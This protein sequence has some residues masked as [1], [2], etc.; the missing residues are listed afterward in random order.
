M[1]TCTVFTV[2]HDVEVCGCTPLMTSA[3]SDVKS[4]CDS[5]Y[6]LKRLLLVTN[7]DVRRYFNTLTEKQQLFESQHHIQTLL[8]CKKKK[9]LKILKLFIMNLI[10][11]QLKQ[12]WTCS[13]SAHQHTGE[14][15]VCAVQKQVISGETLSR[16]VLW[17]QTSNFFHLHTTQ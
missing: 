6:Y 8:I 5:F 1:N 9:N 4:Q 12:F 16:C 17:M 7:S 11:T 14:I 13:D 3:L 15:W 10:Q 2:L